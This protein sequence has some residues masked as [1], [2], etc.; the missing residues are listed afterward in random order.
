M[1]V[2]MHS[3]NPARDRRGVLL[4]V[5]SSGVVM[6][7]A[8]LV[9][10]VAVA[11][12][13][14]APAA[15]AGDSAAQAGATGRT[16]PQTTYA[17]EIRNFAFAPKELRVPAGAR[18]VWTNRDDEPHL[19]VSVSGAFIASQALDTGD[20]FSAVL[21]KPGTYD[22]FCGMHPQMVGRIVVR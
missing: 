21:D 11:L 10:F 8:A 22:Y 19:V 12:A 3:A 2:T 9:W 5:A 4:K 14:A 16:D 20:S 15:L 13:A 6:R 18:V 1:S 17:I 7:G